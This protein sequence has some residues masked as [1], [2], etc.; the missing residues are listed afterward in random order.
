MPR[1]LTPLR[2]LNANKVGSADYAGLGWIHGVDVCNVGAAAAYV[3]IYDKA[4]A[5]ASTDV[6]LMTIGLPPTHGRYID[7]GGEAVPFALG[8]SIRAVTTAVDNGNTDPG[9]NEVTVTAY[10]RKA[11]V[12]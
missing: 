9:S 11:P 12:Q 7:F 3:K 2:N 8:V 1:G 4:T 5:A 10:V 6:P